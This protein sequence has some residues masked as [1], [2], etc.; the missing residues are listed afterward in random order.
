MLTKKQISEIREHLEKAQNPIFFFDNDP[1]GLC[2]FLLLQRYIEHGKGVP[3]KS[4]PGLDESYF[5]KVDELNGDY[6]FILD[7][8]VVSDDFFERARE[9]N[10]PVV[11]IDHHD[12]DISA[13][14][15]FVNYYNPLFNKNKKNEPVTYLC[16]HVSQRKK[17]IWLAAVGCISD[18]FVPD[19]YD[20]V[21]EKY[22]DLTID[23]ENAFEIVYNSQIGKIIRILGFALKDR[24]TNVINMMKFLMKAETPYGVLEETSRNRTMHGRYNEVNEKYSKLVEKAKAG[25][26]DGKILFFQYSGDLS[27]SA[28]IS[29]YL[30]YIFQEKIIIVMRV[31]GE[32]TSISARGKNIRGKILGAIE[33]LEGASGGGHEDAVGARVMTRDLEKFKER[34]KHIVEDRKV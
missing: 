10:V 16:W 17:D 15:K 31:V 6:I 29:N 11:W 12:T 14:P 26:E 34:L 4:F 18:G 27:I 19:F 13:I 23:S 1:D 30:C 5:R 7:K 32:R 28:E 2:S 8:P 3:I 22:P 33:N 20:E 25:A 9:R 24:T 21:L